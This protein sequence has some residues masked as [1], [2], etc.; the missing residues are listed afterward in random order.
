MDAAC[1]AAA[2]AVFGSERTLIDVAIVA[3]LF[4]DNWG[5]AQFGGRHPVT[6]LAVASDQ[7]MLLDGPVWGLGD[8]PVALAPAPV[9]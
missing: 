4:Y 8:A 9:G 2:V 3:E 1:G 5:A 7:T 6:C